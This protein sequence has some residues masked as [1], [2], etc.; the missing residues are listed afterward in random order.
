MG[1]I[2]QHDH[3]CVFL[4]FQTIF[5]QSCF[6][7]V[8]KFQVNEADLIL[9]SWLSTCH[10]SLT[11]AQNEVVLKAFQECPLPLYLKLSFDEACRW[12][13]FT[14]LDETSLDTSV[15]NA[16][17][18]FLEQVERRHG[19]TL[20]T[21]ALAYITASKNG[22]TEPELE[23]VLSLDDDVLN[24]V[25]QYWTPPLRR[26]PPLLWIRIRSDIG[27]YLIERGADDARVVYWYHRQFIEVATHRYLGLNKEEIHSKLA[28][29]FSGKWANGAA[30]PYVDKEGHTLLKDRLVAA[31]PLVFHS[32]NTEGTI[33]NLR[34]LNELP[35]H[36]LH[37]GDRKRLKEMT[38]C[39]FEFLLTKLR[40]TSTESILDDIGAS[41]MLYPDDEDLISCLLYTSPSPRDA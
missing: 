20:V 21:R 37:S 8:P 30:K 16:I 41:L 15:R 14:P 2:A 13:S 27:D 18:S 28:E 36:L 33:F 7:E 35:Y 23:D 26:L 9:R 5:P 10:R 22:L 25:Y 12:K 3:A 19:K 29:F 31:Q 17:T 24:D 4:F 6:K 40:A 39:N 32:E 1:I 11:S 38:L 34:K